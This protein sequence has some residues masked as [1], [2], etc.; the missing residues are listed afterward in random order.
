MVGVWGGGVLWK[1]IKHCLV[2]TRTRTTHTHTLRVKQDKNNPSQKPNV[3]LFLLILFHQAAGPVD[4]IK[5]WL[6]DD[7]HEW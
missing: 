6:T 4:H 1:D 5:Y 7:L 3:F 2:H